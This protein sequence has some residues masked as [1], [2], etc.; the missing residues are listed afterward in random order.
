MR[1]ASCRGGARCAGWPPRCRGTRA[2]RR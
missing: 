1:S 2:A